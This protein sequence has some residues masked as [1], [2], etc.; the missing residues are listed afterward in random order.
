MSEKLFKRNRT[1]LL[2]ILKEHIPNPTQEQLFTFIADIRN[3]T[4]LYRKILSEKELERIFIY[5]LYPKIG[6]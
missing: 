3:M 1:I 5:E 6:E 2:R 4:V